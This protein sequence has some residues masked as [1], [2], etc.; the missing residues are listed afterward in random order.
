MTALLKL[1]KVVVGHTLQALRYANIN[2]ATLLVNDVQTPNEITN[3]EDSLEWYRLSFELG[4]RGLLLAPSRVEN[5]RIDE[6]LVK[7]TTENYNLIKR[8]FDEL[9]IFNLERV[10]GIPAEES[11]EQYVVYDWFDIK[12]GAKQPSCRILTSKD[13]VRELVFYPSIRKDGN[14]GT[15]KDC[16]TKSFIKPQHLKEFEYS[17]TS[18]RLKALNLMMQN[19]FSGP[20]RQVAEKNYHLSIV[21]EHSRRELYK[22]KKSYSVNDDLPENI[23]LL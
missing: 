7:I 5:I 11:V 12:R 15:F 9:Y 13:F 16:Y 14:N 1:K 8:S 18:A 3:K 21:L 17:E 19:G 4:M 10:E 6:N 20:A 23:F 22:F 2:N